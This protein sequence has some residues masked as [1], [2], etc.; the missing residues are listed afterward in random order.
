M[1][2]DDFSLAK[3][4][5]LIKEKPESNVRVNILAIIT[6]YGYTDHTKLINEY[7]SRFGFIKE[8]KLIKEINELVNERKLI[9][10]IV[11]KNNTLYFNTGSSFEFI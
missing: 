5:H 10:I 7:L 3:L 1:S 4:L 11:N 2:L 8:D 6:Y 9:R